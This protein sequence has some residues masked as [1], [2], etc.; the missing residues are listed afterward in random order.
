MRRA[1]GPA[2]LALRLG[3]GGLFV[4]AGASKLGDPAGFAIEISNYQLLPA[5]APYLAIALPPVEILAG[6]LLA[7]AP[8][9]WRRP[10]ALTLAGLVV[11]F[12]V[13]VSSALARGIDISCGCFGGG[14][15]PVSLWTLA[16]NV[17][18]LAAA[19]ILVVGDRARA[20]ARSAVG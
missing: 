10:A 16:R 7:A 13:A 4:F 19:V 15:A 14:S 18:L 11:L 2:L 17:G 9:G 8:R 20:A 1:V 6:L 3:L 5:L 12:T